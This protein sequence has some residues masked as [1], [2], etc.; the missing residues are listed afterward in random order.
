MNQ[1]RMLGVYLS[2]SEDIEAPMQQPTADTAI[3]LAYTWG[4]PP[5]AYL[6]TRQLARLMVFRSRWREQHA[7]QTQPVSRRRS[8]RKAQ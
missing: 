2:E 8:A 5:S 4:L 6:S 3:D 7:D 1:W